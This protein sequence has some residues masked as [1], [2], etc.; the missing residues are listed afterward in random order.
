V[1]AFE[2][3]SHH[4]VEEAQLIVSTTNNVAAGVIASHFGKNA[5][6]IVIIRVKEP[7]DP[8][9]NSWIPITISGLHLAYR[10][11]RLLDRSRLHQK[12]EKSRLEIAELVRP[13]GIWQ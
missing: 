6:G 8:E 5:K 9:V 2:K 7:K 1:L 4:V 12:K 10:V 13:K 11:L 3:V